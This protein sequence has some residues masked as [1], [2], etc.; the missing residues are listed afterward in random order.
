[1]EVLKKSTFA[2]NGSWDPKGLFNV[3]GNRVAA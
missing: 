2:Q 3:A 1:M